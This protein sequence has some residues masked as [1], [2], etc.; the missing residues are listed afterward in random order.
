MEANIDNTEIIKQILEQVPQASPFR[1]IDGIDEVSQEHVVG[2]YTFKKDEFFYKGHFPSRPI[3]PGV[4]LIE[5]MAQIGLVA[6]SLYLQITA[7]Q[8]DRYLTLFT[9]CEIEFFA[10]VNPGDKVIVKSKKVFFRRAKLKAEVEMTLENGELVASG[11]ISGY[12]VKD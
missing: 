6:L 2:H 8:T 10:Q 12:G 11:I 3:T 1:F 5:T 7:Q 9:D 4:I